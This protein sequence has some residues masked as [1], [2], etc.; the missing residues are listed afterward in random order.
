MRRATDLA[1]RRHLR[2]VTL[3]EM[4]VAIVVTGILLS[5]VSLFTR[6]QIMAYFDVA[7]R[8]E[9]ADAADT[10]LRRSARDLQAALP[11]SV[12]LSGN[13]LEFVPIKDAG[14]YR[15]QSGGGAGDD[16]L[17]FND[18]ADH[19]FDVFGPPVNVALGDQLVIYNLGIPG[20]DVYT[21]TLANS[22]RRAI[23]P[24]TGTVSNLSYTVG[25]AQFPLASPQNRFQIVGGPVS[26]ECAPNAASPDLGT[27]RRHWCYA[28][29]DP[30]PTS[31]G[32]LATY[33]GCPAVQSAVLV[34]GVSACA[35]AYAPGALQRN[36]LVSMSIT[37]TR[38][39]ESVILLHQV[40]VMNTP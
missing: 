16:W 21:T 3:I 6:N 12:R 2:G 33:P 23:A 22:S 31:F 35:F 39:H 9:L 14:R 11:N 24:P 13:F 27:I 32:A 19:S 5:V 4:I 25:G 40:D 18:P 29:T 8:T 36:G 20:S 38:N 15:A 7:A 10:A 30:Q 34:A 28:Y 1:A 37:L 26:F 17:D